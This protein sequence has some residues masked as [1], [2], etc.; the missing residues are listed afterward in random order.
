MLSALFFFLA[1]S[2]AWG[3]KKGY[4]NGYVIF[5]INDTVWGQIKDRPLGSSDGM[6]SKVRFIPKDRSFRQKFSA[7]DLTGYGYGDIHFVSIPL[8]ETKEFLITRYYI[9]DGENRRF[10]KVVKRSDCLHSYEVEFVHED[11]GII[12]KYPLFYIP[13]TREMVR[14]TQGVFGLKE[15]RIAE[16]FDNC[17]ELIKEVE[18]GTIKET[19]DLYDFYCTN[20]R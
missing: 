9:L 16:Y 10:L 15:K 6:F 2:F 5:G 18:N 14:V 19:M 3:Q 17:P 8:I 4:C 7:N 11:N 20:C 12:D 1:A 13:G